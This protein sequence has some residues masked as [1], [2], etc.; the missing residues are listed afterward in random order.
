MSRTLSDTNP[1]PDLAPREE[2]TIPSHPLPVSS[3]VKNGSKSRIWPLTEM[4]TVW[5]VVLLYALGFLCF[6]PK[7]LTNFDGGVL[8]PSGGGFCLGERYR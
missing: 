4:G 8:R 6:Y 5:A 2:A 7:A 3:E 1:R